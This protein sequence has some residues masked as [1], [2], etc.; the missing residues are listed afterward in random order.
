MCINQ[1]DVKER[2]QQVRMM[3]SIY[4]GASPIYMWLVQ[5]QDQSNLA[6]D[7]IERPY[8]KHSGLKSLRKL[9]KTQLADKQLATHWVAVGK[10][11]ERSYWRR[12]WIVQETTLA[13]PTYI[14]MRDSRRLNL[15]YVV[16]AVL[17]IASLSFARESRR[18]LSYL[19][20]LDIPSHLRRG[21]FL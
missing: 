15:T 13:E 7:F 19:A 9:A 8:K 18:A 11:W 4:S 21:R 3:Y 12:S 16:Q 10:L 2:E 5:E 17:A 14:I 20:F 6:I 1:Q